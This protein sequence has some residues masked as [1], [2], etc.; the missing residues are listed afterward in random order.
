[1]NHEGFFIFTGLY[2]YLIMQIT[3][4]T[5]NYFNL[6]KKEQKRIY[7]T[8]LQ[9]VVEFTNSQELDMDFILLQLQTLESKA[10]IKEDY[11]VAEVMKK[12]IIDL[13]KL[14]KQNQQHGL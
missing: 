12:L 1:M 6:S 9:D 11:E 4:L 5:N 13:N 3:D 8:I 2:I 7:T 14:K 10:K